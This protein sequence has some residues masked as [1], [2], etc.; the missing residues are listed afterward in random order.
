MAVLVWDAVGARLFET[1]VDKGVFYVPDGSGVYNTGFAWNGLYTVTETPTGGEAN[2]FY[3]DNIKYLNLI[4]LEQFEGTIEAYTYPTEFIPYDGQHA[5]VVGVSLGQQQRKPFGLAYRTRVG[6]D[7]LGDSFGYKI[8]LL[9]G[10]T[11]QP[12]EKTY[13]TVNDSPEPATFSWTVSSLPAPC[14]GHQ[15]VSLITIDSTKVDPTKLAALET[16][17]YG[18]VATAPALPTPNAVITALT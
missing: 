17:L 2:P 13:N 4:S 5:P 11:A 1:G 12:T 18:A 7:I 8:H 15:P 14:T 6:N 16:T 3:A 9:Y 10:L